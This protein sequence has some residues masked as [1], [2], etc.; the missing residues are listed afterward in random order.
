MNDINRNIAAV[1]KNCG[2]A[3]LVDVRLAKEV[4][5]ILL[6]IINKQHTC[7]TDPGENEEVEIMQELSE[8]DWDVI[9]N[10]LDAVASLAM[11]LGPAFGEV[12]KEFDKPVRK[13]AESTSAAERSA[14]I[15]AIAQ[16]VAAME[17][18][19]TPYTSVRSH[20]LQ[21]FVFF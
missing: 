13:Y 9:D 12:W 18:A 21:L 8:L 7:Q 5:G 10:A 4:A 6:S 17:E 14:S 1:L 2:P 16:C 11:A 15:G 3:V 19:C 20:S